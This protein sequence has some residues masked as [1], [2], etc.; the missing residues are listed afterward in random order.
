MRPYGILQPTAFAE[1]PADTVQTF[2]LVAGTAQSQD[3]LSSG[4]T[5]T[6]NAG[7]AG[8]GIVR[9]SFIS[10]VGTSLVLGVVNLSNTNASSHTSGTS[11]ASSGVNCP[12][13]GTRTFQVPGGSTGFSLFSSTAC[14]AVVEMWRK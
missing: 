4:S 6:A 1:L 11:I 8:A 7:A 12:V 13:P 2:L 10:T 14:F 5:A 9:I 3:W